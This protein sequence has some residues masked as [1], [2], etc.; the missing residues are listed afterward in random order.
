[1]SSE[2]AAEDFPTVYSLLVDAAGR[3]PEATAI[4]FLPSIGSE[5]VPPVCSLNS[6]WHGATS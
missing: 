3:A 6:A 4:T 2:I 5:P 1:M